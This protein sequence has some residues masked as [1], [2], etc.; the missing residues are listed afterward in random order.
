[1]IK[2]RNKNKEIDNSFIIGKCIP[3]DLYNLLLELDRNF[4]YID[5]STNFKI[6]EKYNVDEEIK[7]CMQDLLCDGA[8][9]L[10][11][12]SYIKAIFD[13]KE[14]K[15]INFNKFYSFKVIFAENGSCVNY[16]LTSDKIFIEKYIK[17]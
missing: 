8:N 10:L 11:N 9:D 3:K 12:M 6:F 13:I 15:C 7:N 14:I 16:A 2:Y 4:I 17:K 1:M 5:K